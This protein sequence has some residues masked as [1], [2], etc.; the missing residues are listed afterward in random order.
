M[1]IPEVELKQEALQFRGLT[2]TEVEASRA[3]HGNN[4]LTPPEREPWWKLYLQKFE[5]PVIRILIIAAAITI[6]VGLVD[7]HY[8][9]GVGI[10]IA[11]LLATSLAFVNEYR[12][13][14]EFD[15]LNQVNDDAPISVIREGA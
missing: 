6:L 2:P 4:V 5:D 8:A 13:N 9:E 1:T 3:A 11:I 10:V 14:R 12:A 7:G 15:V